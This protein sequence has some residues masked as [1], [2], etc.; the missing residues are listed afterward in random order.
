MWQVR[1]LVRQASG[2]PQS[3]QVL[4]GAKTVTWKDKFRLKGTRVCSSIL[5]Q[6]GDYLDREKISGSN[7]LG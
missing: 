6:F 7:S 5:G 4:G 1:E 3:M 2:L